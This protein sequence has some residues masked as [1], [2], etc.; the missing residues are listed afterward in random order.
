MEKVYGGQGL[1]G[2]NETIVI[3]E[4]QIVLKFRVVASNSKL[5]EIGEWNYAWNYTRKRQIFEKRVGRLQQ[6]Q[7]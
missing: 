4:Q 6:L 7:Q 5:V 3:H 2:Y 1:L